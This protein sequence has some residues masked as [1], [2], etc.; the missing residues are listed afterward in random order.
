MS[1]AAERI[2]RFKSTGLL[3]ALI[4]GPLLLV[5]I[6]GSLASRA[7]HPPQFKDRQILSREYLPP[8]KGEWQK[9]LS[10]W[11]DLGRDGKMQSWRLG[12]DRYRVEIRGA[13]LGHHWEMPKS[14]TPQVHWHVRG[15]KNTEI[16]IRP[17]NADSD[18]LKNAEAVALY[19][20]DD[21]WKF[22]STRITS[23]KL[24]T[25]VS[26]MYP[27]KWIIL[28][29]REIAPDFN[30]VRISINPILGYGTLVS[31]IAVIRKSN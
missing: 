16:R 31:A 20:S 1:S 7:L 17:L 26:E 30:D 21:R 29:M 6:Y 19:L 8:V 3:T 11:L 25:L 24:D 28:P 23:G 15:G 14:D 9:R 13:E 10:L 2:D 4:I 22:R 18:S 27:G 5:W 12:E